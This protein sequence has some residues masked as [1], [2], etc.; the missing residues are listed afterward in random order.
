M[1]KDVL[2]VI[3]FFPPLAGVGVH[4]PLKF[5]K[6]MPEFGY[7]PVVLTVKNGHNYAYDE[8]LLNDIPKDVKV[9]RTNAGESLWLRNIIEKSSGFVRKLKNRKT[10]KS[11]QTSK[12]KEDNNQVSVTSRSLKDKAFDFVDK[13]FFV[14]DSK[15]RWYRYALTGAKDILKNENIGYIFSSSYPYT[16]HLIAL[17]CKKE[18]G[19]PWIADFRDPWVGNFY[20]TVGQSEKRKK[21]E[22]RMEREV[23]TYADKVIMPTEPICSTY[24]SR[25][26]EFKD[27]FFTI[28]NGFDEN[29]YKNV[30]PL[31]TEKFTIC[32]S[33]TLFE[34]E[35]PDTFIKAVS[36]LFKDIPD[37]SKNVDI[38]FIG[39]IDANYKNQL[40]ES[41]IKQNVRFY[42]YMEYNKVLGYMKSAD[43]NLIILPDEEASI[44]IFSGKIFDYI[45]AE[46][47]ILGIIPH[48][49]VAAKLINERAI[50]KSFDHGEVQK[51]FEFLKK[52]YIGW[53]NGDD[54]RT[55]A[56]EK[57]KDFSRYSLT[58]KLIK[59]FNQI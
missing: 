8:N 16:V 56:M 18:T 24:K 29:D 27:K 3:Y 43:I 1:K 12:S 48:E 39:N 25:Y 37:S 44:G 6:F 52:E 5:V 49:S 41:D 17:E 40:L 33:G 15:I 7:N 2:C 36:M 35:N 20:M 13:N 58:E 28:T 59:L 46:K 54:C 4:R 32:Y 53:K 19:L 45:G 21:K 47:P 50:G 26:P 9:Y 22:E 38:K 51:V 31:R 30:K 11:E 55:N 42:S 57:C 23:I 10:E 34:G 14:P